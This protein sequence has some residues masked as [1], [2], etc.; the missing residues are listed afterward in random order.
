MEKRDNNLEEFQKL[1]EHIKS[2][3]G[4][5]M[6]EIAI[7]N[8][9]TQDYFSNT[10]SRVASQGRNVSPKLIG[11]LKKYLKL[12]MLDPKPE[13]T[14]HLFRENEPLYKNISNGD[15]AR[16]I[17]NQE[18]Y[19]KAAIEEFIQAMAHTIGEQPEAIITR[20]KTKAKA[21]INELYNI[22]QS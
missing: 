8:G 13:D 21:N 6:R 14:N 10:I 7:E 4:K 20:I 15:L 5:N 2:V 18:A 1:L 17:V 19:T 9:F 3:T 16:L 11:T 22:L 12:Q